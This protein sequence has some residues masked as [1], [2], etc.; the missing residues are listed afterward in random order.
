LTA[1]GG[2]EDQC[3]WLKDKFGV[4]WQVISPEIGKYLGGDSPE[5]SKAATQAMFQM[6]KLDLNELK[7][8][9]EAA[10]N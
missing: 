9:Y 8:A 7:R 10:A 1:D 6:K 4:S 5:G 2:E 3:G